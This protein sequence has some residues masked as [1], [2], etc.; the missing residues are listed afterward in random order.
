M[1]TQTFIAKVTFIAV[2][3]FDESELIK[4]V[5]REDFA[6]IVAPKR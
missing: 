4:D 2:A 5:C 3:L 1:E 6:M